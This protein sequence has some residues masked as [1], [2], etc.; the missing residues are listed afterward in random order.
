M[1]QWNRKL[2]QLEF[3]RIDSILNE[4]GYRWKN[5]DGMMIW[6]WVQRPFYTWTGA[7]GASGSSGSGRPVNL[8]ERPRTGI[9]LIVEVNQ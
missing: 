3:A 6:N 7:V 5:Q 2:L 9:E 1:N 4:G 8:T